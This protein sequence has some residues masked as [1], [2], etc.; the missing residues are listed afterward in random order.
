MMG[1]LEGSSMDIESKIKKEKEKL[2][3]E[4]E[5]SDYIQNGNG[6]LP[7]DINESDLGLKNDIEEHN[8]LVASWI[9]DLGRG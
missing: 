8:L 9:D 6:P 4:K 7:P 5:L 2:S 1:G 3:K